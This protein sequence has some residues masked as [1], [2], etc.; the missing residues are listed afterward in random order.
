VLI[1]RY[2]E[3]VPQILLPFRQKLILGFH[4]NSVRFEQLGQAIIELT[5]GYWFYTPAGKEFQLVVL[6]QPPQEEHD[7]SYIINGTSKKGGLLNKNKQT[8][9]NWHQPERKQW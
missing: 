9:W 6:Q 5:W 7:N 1:A 2:Q 3:S 4:T 8:R